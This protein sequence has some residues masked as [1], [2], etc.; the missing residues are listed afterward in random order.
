MVPSTTK[1]TTTGKQPLDFT[2]P[3]KFLMRQGRCARGKR[4]RFVH[5]SAP[6][7]TG[8]AS[9]SQP[10][11]C[12]FPPSRIGRGRG[13]SGHSRNDTLEELRGKS[14][15]FGISPERG[16]CV[17]PRPRVLRLG[18]AS[19][20]WDLRLGHS[21]A[22]SHSDTSAFARPSISRE[23]DCMSGA[24]TPRDAEPRQSKRLRSR[25]LESLPSRRIEEGMESDARTDE[26]RGPKRV[27]D[28]LTALSFGDT[29]LHCA[30]GSRNPFLWSLDPLSGAVLS[31]LHMVDKG[32]RV[33]AV[34]K[35]GWTALH[36]AVWAARQ[37]PAK[38]RKLLKSLLDSGANVNAATTAPVHR[39][40]PAAAFLFAE[41][42][43][44]AGSTPLHL[45]VQSARSGLVSFE[46][47]VKQ[48]LHGGRCTRRC[49]Q[50]GWEDPASGRTGDEL[51]EDPAK[52]RVAS[53]QHWHRQHLVQI[54]ES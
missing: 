1:Q 22:H 51:T 48:L 35:Y 6:S 16:P 42:R 34:N 7:R 49:S 43:V 10:S 50:C 53:M 47:L 25:E 37:E 33:N 9:C 3:C 12:G 29:P 36:V 52:D 4:C 18:G 5:N 8:D 38:Y 11:P 39:H 40:C 19:T 20:G 44:P 31:I 45:A 54:T 41:I 30:A 15:D 46:I 26:P 14:G 2:Q 17:Y 13:F 32:A 27:K 28:A 24:T 21:R 23:I